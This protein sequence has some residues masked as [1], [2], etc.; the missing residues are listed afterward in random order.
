MFCN[1]VCVSIY[2]YDNITSIAYVTFAIWWI[3]R[4]HFI[5]KLLYFYLSNTPLCISTSAN[6]LGIRTDVTFLSII[7]YLFF[8][9]TIILVLYSYS[10]VFLCDWFFTWTKT[11]F[12]DCITHYLYLLFEL[13]HSTLNHRIHTPSWSYLHRITSAHTY[14]IIILVCT[15]D[16]TSWPPEL[17]YHL[18]PVCTTPRTHTQTTSLLLFA[19]R[20]NT[21]AHQS[22]TPSCTCLHRITIAYTIHL[23]VH[24]CTH[25][26]IG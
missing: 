5:N 10:F 26:A 4:R 9:I 24:V 14:H 2:V 22:H 16:T 11:F 21:L 7:L 25:D 18:V 3:L 19:V 15:E 17:T 6:T 8:T 12:F 23:I 20:Y 13:R 1:A